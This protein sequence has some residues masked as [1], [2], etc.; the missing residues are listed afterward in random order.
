[1]NLSE[2]DVLPPVRKTV[3]RHSLLLVAVYVCVGIFMMVAVF[4][5]SGTTPKAIHLNYDSIAAVNQ[6]QQAWDG[7]KNHAQY[8]EKSEQEWVQQFESALTFEE[9]NTTEV[10]EAELAKHLRELWDKTKS[11]L[12]PDNGVFLSV[13]RNLDSINNVNEKGM[14][15]WVEKSHRFSREVFL[16]TVIAF[17]FTVLIA[18]YLADALAVKIATPLRELS[19][20]LKQRP[21]PGSPLLLPKPETLEMRILTQSILGLWERVSY[22]QTLNLEEISAQRTKLEAVL[23]SVEDAVLVLD[24]EGKIVHYNSGFSSV[25]AIPCHSL[26]GKLW[27]DL[28]SASENYLSLR[29]ALNPDLAPGYSMELE[30]DGKKKIFAAR[31]RKIVDGKNEPFGDLYLLHDITETKQRDILRAEF[32][33]VLSHEL[34]TPLQSLGTASELLTHRKQQFDADEKMLIETISE[35]TQRIKNVVNEFIQ[36]GVSDLHSLRLKIE[37][38]PIQKLIYQWMQPTQVIGKERD[39]KI[40]AGA[41][42]SDDVVVKIDKVKF[43]WAIT[44][45]LS[46]ALRVSPKGSRIQVSVRAEADDTVIE[47]ADEGPGIAL[48]V[49]RRMFEPYFQANAKD[50]TKTSGF[51][52]LGLTITRD[53]VEA[54]HG[55]IEYAANLPKGSIFRIILPH[56]VG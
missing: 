13:R 56:V 32:I 8:P 1:M 38:V 37:V 54:H 4:L 51:L 40:E 29:L 22:F 21:E 42:V 50:G 14:F 47:I 34:K 53:V 46:N 5:A 12:P 36:V 17:L 43:S 23:T 28:P 48:E 31:H 41:T 6:M 9:H 24:E 10:G 49:Q 3:F 7:I 45:L 25:L 52:G 35:D 26:D 2:L 33:G 44:N 27:R 11:A 20:V 19:S 16:I 18:L 55:K 30:V 15:A 39:I